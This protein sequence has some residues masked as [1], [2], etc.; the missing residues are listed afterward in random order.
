MEMSTGMSSPLMVT[1]RSILPGGGA[2]ATAPPDG[3]WTPPPEGRLVWPP[4][5]KRASTGPPALP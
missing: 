5:A 2:T 1:I 4:L 3:G